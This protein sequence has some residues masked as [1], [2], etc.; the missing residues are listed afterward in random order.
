MDILIQNSIHNSY[1]YIILLNLINN[2]PIILINKL[3]L[4]QQ[5]ISHE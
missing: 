1:I 2:I 3:F 4:M 5:S